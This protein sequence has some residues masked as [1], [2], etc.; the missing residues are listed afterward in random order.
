MSTPTQPVLS[1]PSVITAKRYDHAAWEVVPAHTHP[2]SQFGVVL[3]GTMTIVDPCGWWLAPPGMGVWVPPG[4]EHKAQYSEDSAI[5]LILLAPQLGGGPM[6]GCRTLVVSDLGRELALEAAR[7][8]RRDGEAEALELCARLLARDLGRPAAGPP[9]FVAQGRDRRLRRVTGW[10]RDDPGQDVTIADL[11]TRAGCSA[12]TLAR[13]FVAETGLPFGRWR[14][15]VRVVAAVDRLTRGQSITQAA[16][17]LGYQSAS[18]FTTMF[19]RVLGVPP[20]RY[21]RGLECRR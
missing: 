3:R 10:L 4:I 16:L 7:L 19:T 13:L 6:D 2:E 17:D 8:C 14:D 15:H 5:V 21:V 18:S 1:C 11:A 9:L 20:G 12:R